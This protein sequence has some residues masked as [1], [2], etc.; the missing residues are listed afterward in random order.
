MQNAAE[1]MAWFLTP[2]ENETALTAAIGSRSL[3]LTGQ[4][5]SI[6][7]DKNAA[8]RYNSAKLGIGSVN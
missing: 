7:V 8:F 2:Y 1:D 5:N 4:A 6:P 3:S